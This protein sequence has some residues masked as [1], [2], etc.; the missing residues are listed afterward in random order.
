MIPQQL[1]DYIYLYLPHVRPDVTP[2]LDLQNSHDQD[3][4]DFPG[5]TFN[6]Q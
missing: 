4:K 3:C 2:V 1:Y 5:Y 6:P